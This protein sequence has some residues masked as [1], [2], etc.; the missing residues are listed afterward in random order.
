MKLLA[1]P[2]WENPYLEEYCQLYQPPFDVLGC[3]TGNPAD[4]F[5]FRDRGVR[6]YAWAIP[7]PEAIACV[8]EYSPILE[9]GAG[10]GYWARLLKLA[11]ADVLAFDDRSWNMKDYGGQWSD[12]VEGSLELVRRHSHRSLFLCWP[13]FGEP[14]ARWALVR[15]QGGTVIFIGE[16]EDG[17]TAD[18][19]FYERLHRSWHR[20]DGVAIPQHYAI[21]DYLGV[22]RRRRL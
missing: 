2:K 3:P 5:R 8:A 1:P 14:L 16:Q 19:R 22:Y 12:V 4:A 13:P 20:I 7:T 11:G 21:H 10:N 18:S 9:V 17:C 6:Q 15:Y